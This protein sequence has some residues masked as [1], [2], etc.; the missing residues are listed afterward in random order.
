MKASDLFVRCLE[1]EDVEYVFGIP[2][3]ENLDVMASMIGS[4]IPIDAKP[5]EMIQVLGRSAWYMR[6]IHILCAP[7]SETTISSGSSA[8]RR[9]RMI[10]CG[11]NGKASSSSCAVNSPTMVSRSDW[12][13]DSGR[14]RGQ[15]GVSRSHRA[16][17]DWRCR[18]PD[19]FTGN[20][21]R[22]THRRRYRY[23]GVE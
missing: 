13:L 2:G 10:R 17:R 20:R 4:P 3:E 23:P 21:N 7:T 12:A 18:L 1:N 11:A 22:A 9:S 5:L 16:D 14:D 15:A 19:E 8:L 6:A